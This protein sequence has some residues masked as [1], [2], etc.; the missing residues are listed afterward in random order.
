MRLGVLG[1]LLVAEDG[2]SYVPSAPKVRQLL[3]L[4]LLGTNG[5]VS[6]ASCIEELW[7]NDPPKSVMSTLQTYVFQLRTMLRSIPSGHGKDL[8]LTRKHGYELLV[9]VAEVDRLVF[10]GH[11][12]AA[13]AALERNEHSAAAGSFVAAMGAWR[14]PA[15]TDVPAG[16]VLR[17]HRLELAERRLG[18]L[19]QRIETDLHLGRHSEVLPQLR[20][21]AAAHPTHENIHAQLMIAL[22]GTGRQAEA[23]AVF[24]RLGQSLAELFGLLPCPRIQRLHA[25]ISSTTV[26]VAVARPGYRVAYRFRPGSATALAA[27]QVVC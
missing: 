4:L 22:H 2:V 26:D 1:P 27:Q 6:V 20:R 23:V 14:G 25:M 13:R 11:V 17:A 18:V 15:L 5:F 21:L 9:S 3:A 10:D 8:L 7:P 12:Q 19:E 24:H 16:P